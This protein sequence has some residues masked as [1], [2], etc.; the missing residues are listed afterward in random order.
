MNTFLAILVISAIVFG[1]GYVLDRWITPWWSQRTADRILRD[2]RSGKPTK[3]GD[4]HIEISFDS[5]GFAVALLKKTSEKPVSIQWNRVVRVVAFKRDLFAVDCIC[6]L[7]VSDDD[8]GVEVDEEMKGWQDFAEALPH[9]L[10]G[11]KQ[12][13]DWFMAVA[14]PA[15]ATN[16]TEIFL[17]HE[18]QKA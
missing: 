2:I 14:H 15:F 13:S 1:L 6:L 12:W 10:V 11:C 3:P 5:T 9:Y 18:K 4:Y 16:E 8:T 7:F 17:R